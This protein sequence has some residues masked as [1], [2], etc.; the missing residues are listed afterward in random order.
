MV[1]DGQLCINKP[2][3][4][5]VLMD[6][7]VQL[8]VAGGSQVLQGI[9]MIPYI[10]NTSMPTK[11]LGQSYLSFGFLC[12]GWISL[13]LTSSSQM[14]WPRHIFIAQTLRPQGRGQLIWCSLVVVGFQLQSAPGSLGDGQDLDELLP[15]EYQGVM[16]LPWGSNDGPWLCLLS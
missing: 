14:L 5:L 11:M 7:C 8:Q 6:A 9:H 2:E 13:S 4:C 1:V 12:E 16:L 15:R 10:E 3:L